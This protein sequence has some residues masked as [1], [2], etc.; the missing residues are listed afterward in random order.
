MSGRIAQL[1]SG[2]FVLVGM[3]L[4]LKNSKGATAVINSLGG[5]YTNGVKTLQGR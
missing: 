5:V 3:Y 4:V 1:L 2:T